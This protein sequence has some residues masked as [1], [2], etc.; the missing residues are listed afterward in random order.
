MINDI[1]K[2]STGEKMCLKREIKKNSGV[3]FS[4]IS[5]KTLIAPSYVSNKAQSLISVE[6]DYFKK[7]DSPRIF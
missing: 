4:T 2:V 3:L 1:K 7:L 5:G 6:H